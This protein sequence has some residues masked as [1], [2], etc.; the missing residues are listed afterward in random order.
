[1]AAVRLPRKF[2][3]AFGAVFLFCG[4]KILSK[5][6]RLLTF[7]GIYTIFRMIYPEYKEKNMDLLK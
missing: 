2:Q 5:K 7:R 1:M 4:S 6:L 3:R